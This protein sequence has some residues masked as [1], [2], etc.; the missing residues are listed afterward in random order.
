MPARKSKIRVMIADDHAI[1]RSGLRLL[2]NAQADIEVARKL[3]MESRPFK[4][5]AI[6]N[7]MWH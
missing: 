2:V 3:P 1:L 5:R 6:Q 7:R 4:R